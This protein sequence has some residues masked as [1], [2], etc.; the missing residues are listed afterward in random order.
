MAVDF[1]HPR[2]ISITQEHR[3]LV[4]ETRMG[5]QHRRHSFT[6]HIHGSF[7]GIHALC[8]SAKRMLGCTGTRKCSRVGQH[9]HLPAAAGLAQLLAVHACSPRRFPGA[10]TRR[11]II[12]R[13]VGVDGRGERGTRYRYQAWR[14]P[15]VKKWLQ[16]VQPYER[17]WHDDVQENPRVHPWAGGGLGIRERQWWYVESRWTFSSSTVAGPGTFLSAMLVIYDCIGGTGG[18]TACRRE[19]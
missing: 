10:R 7:V 17:G 6:A 15:S 12:G 3:K 18:G 14:C 4:R 8:R 1:L 16:Q 9:I 11:A 2:L 5:K 13:R 19:S